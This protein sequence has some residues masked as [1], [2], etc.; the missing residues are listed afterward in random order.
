MDAI[1]GDPLR[2]AMAKEENFFDAANADSHDMDKFEFFSLD[3][4]RSGRKQ[5]TVHKMLIVSMLP[6][7]SHTTRLAGSESAA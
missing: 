1:F 7:L 5:N 3:D 2:I 4:L 6:C